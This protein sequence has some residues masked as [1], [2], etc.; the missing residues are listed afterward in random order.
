MAIVYLNGSYIN[1]AEAMISVNDRGFLFGDGVYE[2]TR[3]IRGK[4]IEED[5]HWNRLQNGLRELQLPPD[6]IGRSRFAEISARLLGEAGYNRGDATVYLQITR[7]AAPRS[8]AFPVPAATPTVYAFASPFTIPVEQRIKGVAAITIPD[9]RWSRCD[10]K[11]IQLLPN[12]LAKQQ[13]LDAGAYDVV[14]IRDGVFTEASAANV[15]GV[16]DGELR[17]FPLSPYILPGVTRALVI[18][19]AGEL[20]ILVRE[21]PIAAD[22][23]Q[24]LQELFL[25]GTTTD[26]QPVVELDGRPVGNGRTGPVT[27]KLQRAVMDVLGLEMWKEPEE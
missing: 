6:V 12:A 10:I 1:S 3:A 14:M 24:T 22:Q 15:F 9:I 27:R 13:A 20:G 11:T 25:T 23:R 4:L 2:V 8:H 17:T 19:L 26:V 18:R 7:G 5:T 16:I 21:A